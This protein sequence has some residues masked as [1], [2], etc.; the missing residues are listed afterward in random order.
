MSV[1]R[2]LLVGLLAM[3]LVAC[4]DYDPPPAAKPVDKGAATLMA[5]GKPAVIKVAV[6]LKSFTN[7][8]FVEMA[9]GARQ[10]QAETGIE[11]EI[12]TSTPDTSAEQQIRL[13]HSQIKAGVN[14]IVISPV[15]T[16]LL[17]PAMKAAHD[18][19]I[20][21]VNIDERLNAEALTANG[22]YLVPYVGV[23]SEQGAYQA[24]KFI[25]DKIGHPTE[26]AIVGGIPGTATAIERQ[27]GAQRAFQE[28]ALLRLVPS[29][30][31]NWKADEAYE[32]AR[33]LFKAHPKIGAVYCANDLMAIGVIK[34]LQESRNSKV[35][36]GG[37]DALEEARGA[38][39][40]GQMAVT[41]DQRAAQQGYLGVTSALKLLRGE[42]VPK[43]LLVETQLVSAGGLNP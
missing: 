25:A 20:K 40:A 11:L 14:A 41:V 9:K 22:L 30:A 37:F 6:I 23:D 26:V 13:V 15:D 4:S 10:A 36:V 38:I 21:I 7:P 5:P 1:I 24:A 16:R 3:L 8:F 28:K 39:R 18:A 12:K 32:L 2:S 31:A 43:V 17:V 42:A 27:Q 33:R 19:G 35:L 29:G 34:Y